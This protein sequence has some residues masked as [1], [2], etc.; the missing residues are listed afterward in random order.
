VASDA[1]SDTGEFTVKATKAR[2]T[3][4]A[5]V[6]NAALTVSDGTCTCTCTCRDDG[7]DDTEHKLGDNDNNDDDDDADDGGGGD[8]GERWW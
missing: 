7:V 5:S 4:S 6:G 8:G 3:V 2:T 1:A